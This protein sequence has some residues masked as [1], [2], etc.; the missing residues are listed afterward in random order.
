MTQRAAGRLRQT[1]G[2]LVAIGLICSFG[3]AVALAEPTPVTAEADSVAGQTGE[4]VS[5]AV[6]MD[7]R[8]ID[9]IWAYSMEVA[10]DPAVLEVTSNGGVESSVDTLGFDVDTDTSGLVKVD[11]Q[12]LGFI[13]ER[14][15]V[16]TI[17]FTVK[18]DAP[19][20]DTNVTIRSATYT[21]E[22]TPRAVPRLKGGKVSV[23]AVSR[24]TVGAGSVSGQ[25]GQT[26]SVPVTVTSVSY[27]AVSAYGIHIDFDPTA[28]EV[29]GIAG[30]SGDYF[31]SVQDNAQ[32]WLK[33]AWVDAAGGDP[34]IGAGGRL[35][36]V[37]FTIKANA[38]L[39]DKWLTV[40]PVDV[41]HFTMT[42]SNANEMNKTW[43][44]GKVTVGVGSPGSADPDPSSPSDGPGVP[45]QPSGGSQQPAGGGLDV[46]VNGKAENAGTATTAVVDGRT[47]TTVA[48]DRRK[49]E[50][51]LA[52]EGTGATVTIPVAGKTDVVSIGLNGQM[53]RGMEDKQATVVVRTAFA[54]YTL[55]AKRID[56]GAIAAK[57][58]PNATLSDIEVRIE[59]AAPTAGLTK[60]AERAAEAGD[61]TVVAPPVSFTVTA[62][63]GGSTIDVSAFDVYVERTIALPDDAD[64]GKITTAVVVDPDGT[65]RHVPTRVT[66]EGGTYQAKVNS[67]TNS[68]YAVVWHPVE[69]ADV[70]SHWAKDAVNDI[71]SRMIANGTGEG[72]FAPDREV[73]R[74]E[75]A[76][77]LARGLGLKP[78]S[79]T[80]S[81]A[82]VKAGDWYEGAV[83]AA[84]AYGLIGGFEDGTFRAEES[85][86]RE[87]AM[88]IVARAM[89]ITGLDA[90]SSSASSG[91]RLEAYADA[92][93]VAEWARSA[94]ADCLQAGLVNGR[95]ADELAPQ[96]PMTRAEVAVIVQRLLHKSELI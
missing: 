93:N 38:S 23:T 18:N 42:D 81:F 26:V 92:D 27:S 47:V 68:A 54:T 30:Q 37:D 8:G 40:H 9:G 95:S 65:V 73:T 3:S 29:A 14:Q 64:P 59:I 76:A 83:E 80:N 77:I 28:L 44:N 91:L 13:T 85:I 24:V 67:L 63:H 25:A 75:F 46:L 52:A 33:A 19:S 11:A 72:T 96:G 58:G 20:G 7:P 55:P 66:Q 90:K 74:A 17:R 87:Q 36:T 31:F 86:T 2:L 62:V 53:V 60:L 10:Y 41:H 94:A 78:Q 70:A 1:I 4:T 43:T 79:G 34:G 88:T 84:Y 15:P 21:D 6:Y 32:G 49:L 82:D 5:V 35:F 22:T 56:I 45:G 48:V 16:F 39:G 51:K 50:E 71:G 57:L 61:F 12:L 69:F 89:G